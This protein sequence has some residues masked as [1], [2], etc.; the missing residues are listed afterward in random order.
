MNQKSSGAFSR[1]VLGVIVVLVVFAAV[2]FM[3]AQNFQP[4]VQDAGEAALAAERIQ[5]VGA[6]RS[7]EDGAA[8]LAEAQ[9]A[10]AQ[11]PVEKVVVDGES[12]YN[13]LC[14]AC[15]AT[16]V[17]DAPIK[18][19]EMMAAREAE[20]GID[21]LVQSAIN[22]LNAMPPRGGNPALTDEQI[23]AAIEFMLQ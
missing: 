8:A 21:G 16:G 11:A 4:V 18:G 2:L 6:V 10:A 23:R 17:S 12:V 14:M 1:K 7:G 9:A 5:P 13:S 22:G 3:F 19:S 20:K 15:H